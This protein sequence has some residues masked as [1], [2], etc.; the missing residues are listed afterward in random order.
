MSPRNGLDTALLRRLALRYIEHLP[1]PHRILASRY[2]LDYDDK[3]QE[4]AGMGFIQCLEVDYDALEAISDELC[5]ECDE[6]E[7][8]TEV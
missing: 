2:L 4:V 1:R 8:E 6:T 7:D 5:G 3:A